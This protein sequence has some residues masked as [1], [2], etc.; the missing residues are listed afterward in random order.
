RDFALWKPPKEG[1]AYWETELGAGRPGWHIECTV[2]SMKYLGESFD[3]HLGGEDLV[4]PH[5]ENE[6]AQAEALTHKT[7]SRHWMHVRFLLVEGE[8]MSKSLGNFYT[9]RDLLLKGHKPSAVRFLLSSVPY[10][11]QL[12]FTFDGLKQAAQSVDRL[13]NLRSRLQMEKFPEGE[14]TAMQEL[15]RS[16]RARMRAALEDDLNT[17]QALAAIFDLVREAN[18]AAD[19]GE[20][21]R[22]DIPAL[23][24][25]LQQFDEIFAV[26]DDDD[27][28]KIMR[29]L[30]WAQAEGR[31]VEAEVS[32]I[33]DAEVEALV[34]ERNAAKK[35][36]DFTR[37]D[38]IRDQLS[39]QG[40]VLEDTKDG[41]RWKRK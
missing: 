28:H 18:T 13:R 10:R 4:F 23:L 14:S 5:H 39:A 26:L 24:G 21:R 31:Q 27:Q 30:E 25:A 41:V 6:I 17:A 36:R 20:L 16:T 37:S 33:S 9:V 32:T 34:A 11:K 29:V 2:M 35:A 7:F 12:N 3:L 1:E 15:A 38:A 19:N 40:I 8:K 22:G